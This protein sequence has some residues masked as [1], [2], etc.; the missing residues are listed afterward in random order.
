M[1][2]HCEVVTRASQKTVETGFFSK[3]QA[4]QP[5]EQGLTQSTTQPRWGP[6]DPGLPPQPSSW[7][8]CILVSFIFSENK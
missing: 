3:E 2:T 6:W 4:S 5:Q 1:G 8:L 7:R